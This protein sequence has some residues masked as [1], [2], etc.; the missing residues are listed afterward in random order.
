MVNVNR[1]TPGIH[2]VSSGQ[3]DMISTR[4]SAG[5]RSSSKT[6]RRSSTRSSWPTGSPK[7]T[8]SSC[9]SWSTTT[10]TTSRTWPKAVKIPEI[11]DVDAFLAPLK[12]SRRAPGWYRGSERLRHPRHGHGL[13]RSPLQALAGP[14][15]GQAESRRDRQA[16]GEYFGRSYGGQL[17]EYRN[18]DAEITI[19]TSGSAA[20]TAR[21]V[22]DAKRAEGVKVGLVKLRLYRPFPQERIIQALQGKKAVGVIDR[23]VGFGWKY[24]PMCTEI[25]AL[26]P[27]IGPAPIICY[28]DGVAKVDINIPHI[29][30]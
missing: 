16:F 20:G 15:P 5:S 9:R 27:K 28:I 30:R 12:S 13:R 18:E 7:T 29:G 22:V 4:D 6:T 3:Q 17:E 24:G 2:A 8:T 10:A 21:T 14:R 26:P 19:V 1:E 25:M 23:S 11:T